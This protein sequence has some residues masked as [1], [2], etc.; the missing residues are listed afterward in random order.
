M[1]CPCRF[2]A[3][4]PASLRTVAFAVSE[5]TLHRAIGAQ[6]CGRCAPA[7]LQRRPGAQEERISRP[8]AILGVAPTM[9]STAV[10]APV[11][12]HERGGDGAAKLLARRPD[13]ESPFCEGKRLGWRAPTKTPKG[14]CGRGGRR[15]WKRRLPPTP[16]WLAGHSS[17]KTGAGVSWAATIRKRRSTHSDASTRPEFDA[18]PGQGRPQAARRGPTL[19]RQRAT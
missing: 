9:P 6:R 14:C 12:D 19:I 4:R 2:G 17:S 5:E 11:A 16:I 8:T 10:P 3:A 7:G 13:V 1:R 18:R 15:A